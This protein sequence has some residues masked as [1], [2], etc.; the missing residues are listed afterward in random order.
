MA[1]S[2]AEA[3]LDGLL[4]KKEMWHTQ[5]D[6]MGWGAQFRYMT[7][8]NS[9]LRMANPVPEESGGGMRDFMRQRKEAQA[10]G[11]DTGY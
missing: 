4:V 1:A 7:S 8:L 6:M 3:P 11:E 5:A 2:I 10:R 9:W